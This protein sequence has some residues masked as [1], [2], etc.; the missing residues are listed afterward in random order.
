[1]KKA[2]SQNTKIVCLRVPCYR[3][4]SKATSEVISLFLQATDIIWQALYQSDPIIILKDITIFLQNYPFRLLPYSN[5]TILSNSY[6][7]Q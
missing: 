3:K 2:S 5:Q 4:D 7:K 1:M 6:S